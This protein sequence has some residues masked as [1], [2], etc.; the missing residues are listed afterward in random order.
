MAVL[1]LIPDTFVPERSKTAAA[2][3]RRYRRPAAECTADPLPFD[4]GG[5]AGG[6]VAQLDIGEVK[7]SHVRR[8]GEADA[9]DR[10]LPDQR[11]EL[12]V[13]DDQARAGPGE[14]VA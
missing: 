8:L 14:H 3:R 7:G 11:D 6:H 10:A 4:L 12:A 1:F 2:C 5:E 9:G 13:C